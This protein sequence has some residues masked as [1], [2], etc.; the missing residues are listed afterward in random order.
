MLTERLEIMKKG[1]Y[2]LAGMLVVSLMGSSCGGSMRKKTSVESEE[3][4]L[5]ACMDSTM[6]ECDGVKLTWILDNAQK[7]L[8]P[9]K[10]FGNVPQQL[11]DSLGIADGIPSSVSAFLIE[12]DGKHILFDAGMGNP[13]S[14]LIDGLA[15]AGVEPVDVD[16]L[17]LTHFHGDHIGGL[18]KDGN[19]VF[20]RAEVYAARQEY[21]GWMQMPDDKKAQVVSIMAAYKDRMHLFEYG[22]TLPGGI[23][24]LNG[25]GHTPGHSVFQVGA[26]LIVGDLVHG[27]ALQ[28]VHPEICAAYDMDPQAAVK[29]RKYYLDYAREN[30]LFIAGMHQPENMSE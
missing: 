23:I 29:T 18:I 28:L 30:N 13:D 15:A 4:S 6:M 8:M 2:L 19:V 24:A 10:L 1:M 26:F 27:A 12:V 17:C 20:P 22:D 3:R 25:E 14:R 16:Y 5:F 11:I 21:E 9:L 7:R